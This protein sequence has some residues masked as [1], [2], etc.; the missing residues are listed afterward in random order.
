[1]IPSWV[2]PRWYEA[3]WYGEAPRRKVRQPLQNMGRRVRALLARSLGGTTKASL[4]REHGWP[5]SIID[6]SHERLARAT[7]RQSP[8]GMP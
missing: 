6:L 1:M 4:G 2:D 8:R 7:V 3:Y 5:S